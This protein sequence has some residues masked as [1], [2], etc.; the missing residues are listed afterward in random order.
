MREAPVGMNT[1]VAG[2]MIT[3][4]EPSP[5]RTCPSPPRCPP[6]REPH[7]GAAQWGDE[8]DQRREGAA[9]SRALAPREIDSRSDRLRR[10]ERAGVSIIVTSTPCEPFGRSRGSQEREQ[11]CRSLARASGLIP[12]PPLPPGPVRGEDGGPRAAQGRD[13]AFE[14]SWRVRADCIGPFSADAMGTHP[15][16]RSAGRST[17]DAGARSSQ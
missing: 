10:T 14:G 6:A 13:Q 9:R 11:P 7:P 8:L 2:R 5:P 4:S 15:R 1:S 17:S 12:T 16:W 3:D